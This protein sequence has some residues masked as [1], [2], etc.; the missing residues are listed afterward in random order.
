MV[1]EHVMNTKLSKDLP[2][3]RLE[4]NHYFPHTYNTLS[5]DKQNNIELTKILNV[6]KWELKKF[7]ILLNYEYYNVLGA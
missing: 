3:P 4:K 2:W 5:I 7:S 6:P 1:H